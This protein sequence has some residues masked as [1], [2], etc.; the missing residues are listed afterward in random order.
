MTLAATILIPTHNHGPTL[1]ASVASALRQTVTDIEVFIIGDGVTD[2]TRQIVQ[3]LACGDPRVRFFDHPKGPRHGE[4]YRHAALA[5]ARGRIVCYLSDDDLYLPN[6]VEVMTGLL[7]NADFA[8]ALAASVAPDGSLSTW[9]VDLAMPAFRADLLAGRNRVPFSAGAH[10]MDFY[11][12]LPV[13]WTAAPAGLPTD[14]HMWQKFLRQPECRFRAGMTPT[15]LVFPS[16]K[17]PQ[18]TPTE[19]LAELQAWLDRTADAAGA[20]AIRDQVLALAVQ[21]A[22]ELKA[23]TLPPLR[24]LLLRMKRLFG[25]RRR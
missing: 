17:R 9:T 8:H 20:A 21:R 7:A 11:R 23:K 10:T 4:P 15:V 3:V 22:A 6:H 5:E 12:R 1:R 25:K 18:M 19:R 16:P 14:L 13:G 2:E 24:L